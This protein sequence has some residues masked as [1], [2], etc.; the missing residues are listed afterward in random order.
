MTAY[1]PFNTLK[2]SSGKTVISQAAAEEL[3]RP[4]GL[5]REF[6]TKQIRRIS[7]SNRLP[8]GFREP[9]PLDL[10]APATL[11]IEPVIK[12]ANDAPIYA[13]DLREA[14][15]GMKASTPKKR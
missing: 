5:W 13:S 15:Q 3:A 6:W 1:R 11:H 10:D 4:Q 9:K 7:S 2:G 8:R 14:I 12:H